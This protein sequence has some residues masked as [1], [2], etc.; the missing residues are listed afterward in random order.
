[1]KQL[2]KPPV[3]ST[4]CCIAGMLCLFFRQWLLGSALDADGL[5]I[6]WHPINI[7]IW[8]LTA[9]VGIV[10][11][12]LF[13]TWDKQLVYQFPFTPLSGTATLFMAV[14]YAVAAYPLLFDPTYYLDMVTGIFA[15]LAILCT[16]LIALGQFLKLRMHPLLYCPGVLFFMLYLL[17]SYP[18]W[19]GEPQPQFFFFQMMACVFL[20][21]SV[22][23][24]AEMAA[25]RIAGRN[26]TIFSRAAI[27]LCIA[28][29]P[30]SDRA[31]LYAIFAVGLLLD[32]CRTVKR[33]PKNPPPESGE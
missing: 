12:V 5:L 7:L 15:L 2:S 4:I 19:S 14:G 21:L 16:L 28:A 22:F 6:I 31:L 18:L 8:V 26:Y 11:L 29:I 17:A 30:H 23:T 3:L 33:Q 32:G 27:F 9:L 13:F 1:M 20:L 10:L 25:G 24:R